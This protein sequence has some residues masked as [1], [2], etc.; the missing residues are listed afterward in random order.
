MVV[1][2]SCIEKCKQLGAM[3][4]VCFKNARHQ[5]LHI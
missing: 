5:D 3:G 4:I 1:T 2:R